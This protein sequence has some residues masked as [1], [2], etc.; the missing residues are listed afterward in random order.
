MRSIACICVTE[1]AGAMPCPVASPSTTSRPAS[2][3]ERSKVSPPVR[4]AGL[5]VP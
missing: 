1:S 3:S 4:S 5:K 2:M